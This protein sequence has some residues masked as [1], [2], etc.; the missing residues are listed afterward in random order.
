MLLA[1]VYVSI[2]WPLLDFYF[3]RIL[4][5]RSCVHWVPYCVTLFHPYFSSVTL[6]ANLF[7]LYPVYWSSLRYHAV[8]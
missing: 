5:Y 4:N 3:Y 7:S 6:Q 1:S 8:T 2:V